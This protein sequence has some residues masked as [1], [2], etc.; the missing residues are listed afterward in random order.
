MG[1]WK[2]D[3]APQC[4][5]QETCDEGM[6]CAFDHRRWYYGDWTMRRCNQR[7]WKSIILKRWEIAAEGWKV[8][9]MDD[10]VPRVFWYLLYRT[11]GRG[12]MWAPSKRSMNHQDIL[13]I[14][15]IS[16]A[17]LEDILWALHFLI[18]LITMSYC[19][20]TVSSVSKL[21]LCMYL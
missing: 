16:A 9:H 17:V 11:Q 13:L 14:L 4:N 21:F 12:E 2:K 10:S 5:S 7:K 1:I 19:L 15:T 8:D 6:H 20:G 3:V 18:S